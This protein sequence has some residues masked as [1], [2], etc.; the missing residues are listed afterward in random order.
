MKLLQISMVNVIEILLL[1]SGFIII[2]II[3]FI[4]MVDCITGSILK[5]I[6]G[7]GKN[8]QE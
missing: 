3:E 8:F 6:Q 2:F 5:A 4:S 1:M 7:I